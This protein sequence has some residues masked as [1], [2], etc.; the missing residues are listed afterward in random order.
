MGILLSMLGRKKASLI[1]LLE[2]NFSSFTYVSF[3]KTLLCDLA[4]LHRDIRNVS[5]AMQL[6]LA[7]ISAKHSPNVPKTTPT[8]FFKLG[9]LNESSTSQTSRKDERWPIQHFAVEATFYDSRSCSGNYGCLLSGATQQSYPGVLWY[10]TI[11]LPRA[12][13]GSAVHFSFFE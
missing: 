12:Q 13:H 8:G 7:S 6:P 1:E 3:R 2:S 4:I 5:V 11:F 10:S 9:N